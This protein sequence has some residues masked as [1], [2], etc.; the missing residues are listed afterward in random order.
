[1]TTRLSIIAG[2]LLSPLVAFAAKPDAAD[3]KLEAHVT[4]TELTY[5]C[6]SSSMGSPSS[7]GMR[8]LIVAVIDGKKLELRAN[9]SLVLRTGDYKAKATVVDAD[10]NGYIDQRAYEL[11]MPDGK[12]ITFQVVGELEE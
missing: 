2:L 10:P 1:M 8:L 4:R 5:A 7:C 11:L 3:Y 9:S 12:T 6:S